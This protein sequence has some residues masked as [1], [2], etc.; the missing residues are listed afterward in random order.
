VRSEGEG[1][2][3]SAR[4]L[5]RALSLR[6][7]SPGLSFRGHS[8]SKESL[9]RGEHEVRLRNR[10][11]G[12]EIIRPSLREP[13]PSGVRRGGEAADVVI[14]RIGSNFLSV[15]WTV[16]AAQMLGRSGGKTTRRA[17][18][19]IGACGAVEV[20]GSI[21]VGL[22]GVAGWWPDS[23]EEVGILLHDCHQG[24]VNNLDRIRTVLRVGV[25]C[26]QSSSNRGREAEGGKLR[27][28]HR[29][30]RWAGNPCQCHR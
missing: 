21:G 7:H 22:R 12:M 9:T 20:G 19:P 16:I 27:K 30:T 15:L 29:A 4:G 10:A 5:A 1:G 6:G 2:R 23:V 13:V 11:H 25:I 26:C 3:E 18:D 8:S 28:G 17:G 14:P 24:R